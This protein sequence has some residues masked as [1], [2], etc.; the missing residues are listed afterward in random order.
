MR[1]LSGMATRTQEGLCV[2][3]NYAYLRLLFDSE[4]ISAYTVEVNA[5]L[6]LWRAM[7]YSHWLPSL[8]CISQTHQT[9][10]AVLSS[11]RH[12]HVITAEART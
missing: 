12:R 2:S 7:Q 8:L 9:Q 6:Q 3:Y 5:H 1:L 4:S 10:P 11:V